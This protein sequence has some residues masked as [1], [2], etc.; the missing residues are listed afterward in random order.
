[1][2]KCSASANLYM[3]ANWYGRDI[4]ITVSVNFVYISRRSRQREQNR[5]TLV[6]LKPK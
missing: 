2:P 5:I 4:L 3:S 1:M 6:N